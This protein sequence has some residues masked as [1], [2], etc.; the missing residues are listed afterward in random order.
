MSLNGAPYCCGDKMNDNET[1]TTLGFQTQ[2]ILNR[3]QTQWALHD[4]NNGADQEV[5]RKSNS[6]SP[7]ACQDKPDNEREKIEHRLRE[8]AELQRRLAG[9]KKCAG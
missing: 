6:D 3:L 5:D 7:E 8:I 2:L 4:F 9:N 1:Y